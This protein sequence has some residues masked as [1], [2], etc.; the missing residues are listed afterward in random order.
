MTSKLAW[1]TSKK[2]ARRN[3]NL[4]DQQTHGRGL[5]ILIVEMDLN[6]WQQ[7]AEQGAGGRAGHSKP[8]SWFLFMLVFVYVSA[9]L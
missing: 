4:I 5:W 2:R 6:W 3:H 9:I 8:P 7:E 1:S